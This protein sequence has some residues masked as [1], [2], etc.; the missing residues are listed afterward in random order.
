MV[1]ILFA[2]TASDWTFYMP[3]MSRLLVM[4]F[5]EP[6]IG[7]PAAVWD[8]VFI[9]NDVRAAGWSDPQPLR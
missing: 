5:A 8:H 2:R 6:W 7:F 4:S 9:D 1:D 3:I